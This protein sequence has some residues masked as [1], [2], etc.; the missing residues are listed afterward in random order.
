MKN[1]AATAPIAADT[2][3][4]LTPKGIAASPPNAGL[5]LNAMVFRHTRFPNAAK[6]FLAFMMEAPQYD[7]WL[8]ANIGYWAQPL[9]AFDAS[10]TW[11][12][13]PKVAIFKNTMDT[14]F[15]NGFKGPI[16]EGSAAANADYVMVQMCASVASGQA[17]PEAAA[18]EA[19]RRA[20]RFFRRR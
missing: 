7:P 19:Q 6:A 11:A 3:H 14:D 1:D 16:T 2:E 12:G 9:N 20:A 17:T 5:T 10:A 13:D 8:Q 18:R 4:S 15:W